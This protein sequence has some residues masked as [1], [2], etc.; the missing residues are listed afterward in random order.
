MS[1]AK[2]DAK[3][4]SEVLL[5][6]QMRKSY[7]ENSD[8]WKPAPTLITLPACPRPRQE[9]S[10]Q[11]CHLLLCSNPPAPHSSALPFSGTSAPGHTSC[12]SHIFISSTRHIF[13][14]QPSALSLWRLPPVHSQHN[15]LVYFL[16]CD[17]Q[18]H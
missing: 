8:A 14:S 6:A 13:C 5:V 9:I 7:I 17:Q 10:L 12:L 2:K 3:G 15:I 4:R 16:L 18:C 11:L 1:N